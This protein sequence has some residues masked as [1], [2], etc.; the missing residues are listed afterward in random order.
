MVEMYDDA[1]L[2]EEINSR[3]AETA[4]RALYELALVVGYFLKVRTDDRWL[5][6][7]I[8]RKVRLVTFQGDAK[9]PPLPHPLLATRPSLATCP[10][11]HLS[12]A[13]AVVTLCAAHIRKAP[14]SLGRQRP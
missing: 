6:L 4:E 11:K 12:G 7:E 5:S 14:T 8:S 9:P 13:R 10:T 1:V 3:C 2:T